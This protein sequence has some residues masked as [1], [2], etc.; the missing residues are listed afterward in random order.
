MALPA[1]RRERKRL[2]STSG[3][4]RNGFAVKIWM[5]RRRK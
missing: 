3:M 5:A 1:D 2:I 4:D